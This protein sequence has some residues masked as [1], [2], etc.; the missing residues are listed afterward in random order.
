MMELIGISISP[1]SDRCKWVLKHHRMAYRYTEHTLLFGIP[2]LRLRLKRFTGDITAPALIDGQTRIFDSYKISQYIDSQGGGPKLFAPQ[3]FTAIEH[4]NRVSEEICDDGR[5]FT[6]IK[7]SQDPEAQALLLP[8]FV[9]RAFRKS[10][11]LLARLGTFY[12][13]KSFA[14]AH[15]NLDQ[16]KNN[17]RKNLNLIRAGLPQAPGGFLIGDQLSYADISVACCLQMIKPAAGTYV[18]KNEAT[19]RCWTHPDLA[20]E[21]KDLLAWRDRIRSSVIDKPLA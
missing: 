13:A 14:I 19:R 18:D 20:T 7:V 4:W 21:F 6:N 5:A 17:L 1:Y 9:P 16:R 2:S 8:K 15:E 12:I 3:S 10:L 11:H